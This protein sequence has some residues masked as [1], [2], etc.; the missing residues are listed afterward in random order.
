MNPI[1]QWL[2]SQGKNRISKIITTEDIERPVPDD[3]TYIADLPYEGAD[4]TSLA[5]DVYRPTDTA[6]DPLPIAVFIHGGGF[7]VGSR[8]SNRAYAELLA[9]QGYVVFIPEYRLIDEADGPHAI[10]DV[11]AGLTY[12]TNHAT[13]IGGDLTRVLMIGESAGAYLAL[14]ATAIPKS[15]QLSEALGIEVPGLS[16]RGLVCFGGMFYTTAKDPLGL[17]YRRDLYGSRLRDT[18]FM[19]LMNPED[20]RV[21]SSLPPVLM[22]TSGADFLKAYTLRFN[23]S[24]AMAG[25]DHR[26]IYYQKGRELTHAFPS[27]MPN[28]PQSREVLTE[29]DAWLQGL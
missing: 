9:K 1:L 23:Q 12:L 3:L 22:V 16:V 2:Q 25:H 19:Q 27:L 11:C 15:P 21:E 28:L 24:L 6:A 18:A 5:A 4:G 29:L 20:P 17:V 14:Y 10:A 13:E 8:K 7:F 26:L